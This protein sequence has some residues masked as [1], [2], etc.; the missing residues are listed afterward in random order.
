MLLPAAGSPG[1]DARREA[2]APRS[3]VL[4]WLLRHRKC[5]PVVNDGWGASAARVGSEVRRGLCCLCLC[6]RVVVVCR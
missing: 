2:A 5:R 4:K 6:W 1:M 3:G